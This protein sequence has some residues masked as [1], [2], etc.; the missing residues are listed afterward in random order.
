MTLIIIILSIGISLTAF[1]NKNIS[2]KLTFNAYLIKENNEWYR[3]FSYGFIHADF[4]HLFVN[5]YVLYNFGGYVESYFHLYFGVKA[6]FY[7]FLLYFGGLAISVVSDYARHQKDFFYN[8][9]G[10]SGAVSALVFSGFIFDPTQRIMIFLI[11][12]PMPA[13]VFGILYLGYSAFMAKKKM[14]NIGHSAHFWGAIFGAVFTVA[15][16]PSLLILF[17]KS[18]IYLLHG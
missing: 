6:Y 17:V 9:V 4:I 13:I 15:L 1:Y 16:K 18:I 3:F 7:F 11:P 2:S 8:A 10:A 5:M 12:F 14:D